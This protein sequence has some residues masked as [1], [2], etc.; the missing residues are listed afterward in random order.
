LEDQPEVAE[1][2]K[3]EV[4]QEDPKGWDDEIDLD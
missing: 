4:K 1:E 3:E 2:P